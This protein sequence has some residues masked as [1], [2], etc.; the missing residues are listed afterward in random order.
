MVFE[1]KHQETMASWGLHLWLK[2]LGLG[3]F[4]RLAG[5]SKSCGS[6]VSSSLFNHFKPR[7]SIAT[8][9]TIGSL[10]PNKCAV[11]KPIHLFFRKQGL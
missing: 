11:V 1:S 8:I 9:A 2:H 7:I 5:P 3:L 4:E 10:G 6:W